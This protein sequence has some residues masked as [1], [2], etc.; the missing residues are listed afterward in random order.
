MS[1]QNKQ[2]DPFKKQITEYLESV[3]LKD[4]LFAVTLK[5]PN[6]NIDECIN[7]IF[8]EVKK[9][10]RY[11][12]TDEE[13]YQ[14]AIHYYDEDEIKGIKPINCRVSHIA[15]KPKDDTIQ[16]IKEEAIKN[17]TAT[18]KEPVQPI[19]PTVAKKKTKTKQDCTQTA[20][21]LFD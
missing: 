19:K 15:E 7:Y 5:K 1:T 3:A 13:V 17:S 6:K 2:E 12:W 11:R 4:A 18:K 21:L 10:N 16:K 8:D 14:L 20:L 9:S